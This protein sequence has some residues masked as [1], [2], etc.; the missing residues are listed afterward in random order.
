MKSALILSIFVKGIGAVLEILNQVIITRFGGVAMFGEYSFYISAAEIVCWVFFSGIVK[1]NAFYVANGVD[2]SRFRR[3]YLLYFSVPVTCVLSIISLCFSPLLIISMVAALLYSCQMNLSSYCLAMRRYKLSLFGEYL[4][5][6][7]VILIGVVALVLMVGLSTVTL[8]CVY[9]LGYA[10]SVI[11]FLVSRHTVGVVEGVLS[12]TTRRRLPKQYLTFQMTDVANGLINQAPVI[13]Q[14][15]FT[16]AYQAG[17]LSV[18]LVAK[19]IISFVAGPTSKIYLPEFAKRYYEGDMQGLRKTYREIVLLQLCFVMPICVVLLGAANAVLTVYNPELADYDNYLCFASIVFLVMV[20]FG[21]QGNL[22]SMVGK[23]R[24]EAV[25]KWISL[26]AMVTTMAATF[27]DPLFVMYGIASQ[28]IVDSLIKLYFIVRLLHG[29]PLGLADWVKLFL[30]SAVFLVLLEFASLGTWMELLLACFLAVSLCVLL[31][32]EF[33]SH[34]IKEKIRG[35][36][37][38]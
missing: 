13:I 32:F 10:A 7:V 25:T 34:E 18:V 2:I 37:T 30:P 38:S 17:V 33:F 26:A 9:A 24:V 22:L 35:G 36:R 29:F 28:T 21:P 11:F 31:L 15:A 1:I 6:R 12:E 16:G 4:V 19:K 27:G 8:A 20:L 23:E 14:Y 3:G 5:S